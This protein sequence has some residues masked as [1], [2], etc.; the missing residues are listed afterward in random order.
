MTIT[1]PIELPTHHPFT[2]RDVWSVFSERVEAFADRTFLIW[3]PADDTAAPASWTYGEFGAAVERAAAGLASRGVGRGDAVMIFLDNCP[4]F[5]VTWFACARIGTVAVDT[6]ARYVG[7]E[8][9]HAASLTQPVGVVT[10]HHLTDRLQGLGNAWVVHVDEA[11]GTCPDLGGDPASLP[12]AAAP[13]P[14]APMCIQFTSGTTSR[15]KA[16]LYTHANALWACTASAAHGRFRPDDVSLVHGPLFHTMALFWQTMPSLWVGASVVV[17]PKY[18]RS[19]FWDISVRNRCTRTFF[20]GLMLDLAND[21]IPDHHYESWIAGAEMPSVEETFGVRMLSSWGMTEVVT[22]VLV[23]DLD[24]PG[25]P[26]VIGRVSPEYGVRIV[27]DDGAEATEGELRVRG[28]RGISLFA[29]YHAN[30]D[31]TAE[32]FDELGHWRTGDRVRV[33][34]SGEIQFVSRIKAMLRVGGENV[35]AAEIERVLVEHP[36]VKAAGVVG[37][38]EPMRGEVPFGFVV[39]PGETEASI[40]DALIAHCAERLADFKVPRRICVIDELPESLIGK[41]STKALQ[42]LALEHGLPST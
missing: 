26:R 15:P 40:G 9:A 10:H 41:T 16:A 21:P 30:P 31:A 20:L 8:V 14:S 13:D 2:G 37:H 32:G 34:P 28:I 29:G 1:T 35:A 24:V 3:E 19:R 5:L 11:T 36:A 22:N 18:S 17:V 12:A 38:P 33:L 25:T 7:D 4:A 27:D 39:A 23:G 6:N 42:A